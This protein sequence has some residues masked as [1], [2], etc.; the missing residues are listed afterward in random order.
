MITVGYT[1]TCASGLV[2]I[3]VF[4]QLSFV[5]C[6]IFLSLL[7][8]WY[9]QTYAE[10]FGPVKLLLR[11]R[12][13]APGLLPE[14]TI[15]RC[16]SVFCKPA[17]VLIETGILPDWRSRGC[18]GRVLNATPG[19]DILY[20]ARAERSIASGSIYIMPPQKVG[21]WFEPR[22]FYT[23]AQRRLD[24][25]TMALSDLTVSILLAIGPLTGVL[26]ALYT[27]YTN[28]LE[29][30]FRKVS[31]PPGPSPNSS[32]SIIRQSIPS[33]QSWKVYADWTKT[34]GILNLSYNFP[35]IL[36]STD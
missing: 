3:S 29:S 6:I 18:K 5:T 27:S 24:E 10:N 12:F 15:P 7:L 4:L 35:E 31:Y 28:W 36:M 19:H 25:R 8:E 30:P 14:L 33:S 22:H 1:I 9:M 32:L 34:Y 16:V 23:H 20:S 21:R 26:F 2:A 17:E 11:V 13:P